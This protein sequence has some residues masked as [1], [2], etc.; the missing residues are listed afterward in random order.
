MIVGK[1][2][3]KNNKKKFSLFY[4]YYFFSTIIIFL[5]VGIIFFNSG[6]WQYYKLKLIPRLEAY[7]IFNYT[8]LPSVLL[9][10]MK[11]HFTKVDEIFI[12]ISSKEYE[13]IEAERKKVIKETS[14]KKIANNSTFEFNNYKAKIIHN[15]KI[16]NA[17]I[18]LKGDR[19]IHWNEENK[20]SY[21]INIRQNKRILGLKKFSLQKPRTRNYIY[22]WIFHELNSENGLIKLKYDFIN[23]H[24]NNKDLGIY[25]IEEFFTKHILE[26]NN[27]K[28]GPIFSVQESFE[29]EFINSKFEVYDKN[30]WLNEANV[31]F[32]KDVLNKLKL[33]INS[34]LDANEILDLDMWAWYMATTDL[35]RTYHGSNLKSQKFYYNIENKKFEPVPFDGHYW[36]PILS[37]AAKSDRDRIIIEV[38]NDEIDTPG[39]VNYSAFLARKL[40][41]EEI[42]A[43]KYF[44]ALK[45]ITSEKF[46]DDF[47][48]QR[49]K[50]INKI[51]SL[52]YSDYFFNDFVHFYGPGIYY[53]D[54]S[55]IY[56][57]AEQ[58][59]NKMQ[60]D[61][62]KLFAYRKNGSIIVEN[63]NVFNP[64]TTVNK[65]FCEKKWDDKEPL[66]LNYILKKKTKI[67]K[68]S[69]FKQIKK[70]NKL[71]IFNELT[72][73]SI[74]I[75]IDDIN[76]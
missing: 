20:S 74:K 16:Y 1:K 69:K 46:L 64:F 71:N 73:Q 10:K 56:R 48:N 50:N 44:F 26:K 8:K 23:L 75:D 67:E 17:S 45:K 40:M 43:K 15:D 38:G 41:D 72:N 6:F 22:E 24:V 62:N 21:R 42:F 63:N 76:S 32:T 58:I 65:I 68:F 60:T 35:L 11:G 57:R 13:K 9:L 27:R 30:I 29:T 18:R 14:K 2:I 31:A 25:V 4:K 54:K 5:S 51:S 39:V 55:K 49:K 52:I 37:H 47:F 34:E 66:S 70:C 33:F 36:N 12:K 59:R 53:F 7:G 28:N 61:K 3:K 19:Y